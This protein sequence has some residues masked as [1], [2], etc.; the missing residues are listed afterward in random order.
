MQYLLD[1]L[2]SQLVKF[3]HSMHVL[4]TLTQSTKPPPSSDEDLMATKLRKRLQDLLTELRS[5][6]EGTKKSA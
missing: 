1:Q 4:S 2:V 6:A 3:V 5:G